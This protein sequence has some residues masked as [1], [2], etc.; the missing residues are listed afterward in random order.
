LGYAQKKT[1]TRTKIVKKGSLIIA[2]PP[3][4]ACTYKENAYPNIATQSKTIARTPKAKKNISN[5]KKPLKTVQN[6]QETIVRN[7][8]SSTSRR[9]S[10]DFISPKV[11]KPGRH[12]K[13][14]VVFPLKELVL[15]SCLVEDQHMAKQVAKNLPGKA[16][17]AFQVRPTTTHVIS[18]EERR[19]LNML[20]AIIRGCWVVSKSWLLAS[21][22]AEGWV[23]EE[24]YELV[25]FSAAIKAR[26]LEREADFLP[27][28]CDL[29]IDIGSI[30]IGRNCK[31][32]KRD[33]TD[34]IHL[35]GGH[36]VNQIRIANVILGHDYL[37]E[38]SEKDD[39]V[40]VSEKWL[41]DSL[42]QYCP[43]PFV[44]YMIQK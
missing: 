5:F 28:K 14:P 8:R 15:T 23:D 44:D 1:K 7:L 12:K 33:L 4:P 40:Q 24:P 25:T 13:A 41:L 43:L 42:Q 32:P 39:V 18:G 9:S 2:Q 11:R 3:S 21:L 34:L 16:T 10:F 31:V 35:A 38:F 36:T 22:E 29:L 17:V 26:R 6:N 30:C 37:E 27:P 20:K 19:T